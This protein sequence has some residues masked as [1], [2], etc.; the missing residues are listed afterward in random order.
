MLK[1]SPSRGERPHLV[2]SHYGP[3]RA[4]DAATRRDLVRGSFGKG[5][6][7]GF[8]QRDGRLVR[9]RVVVTKTQNSALT[10][11]RHVL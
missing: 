10:F 1:M 2:E 11:P 5:E 3:P 8:L 4:T 9:G 7:Y 6:K